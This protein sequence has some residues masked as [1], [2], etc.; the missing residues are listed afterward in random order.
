MILCSYY[1]LNISG[2]QIRKRQDTTDEGHHCRCQPRLYYAITVNKSQGQ[3]LDRVCLDLR[4]HPFAHGQLYVG[5][6]HVRNR[7]NIL[8][9]TLDDHLHHS[10][11]LTKNIVYQDLLPS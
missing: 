5:A 9:L 2:Q 8:V 7:S 3:M 10:C 4:E 1:K 11:A 6:S